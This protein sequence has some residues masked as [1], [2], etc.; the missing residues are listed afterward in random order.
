MSTTQYYNLTLFPESTDANVKQFRLALAGE[1]D[2][3]MTKIAAALRALETGKISLP[4]GA[5]DGKVLKA[6]VTGSVV[7]LVW[8]DASVTVDTS[9]VSTGTNAVSGKA[10]Y[11]YVAEVLGDFNAAAANMDALIGGS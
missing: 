3:N 11:D 9:V 8:G 10:V 5:A 7:T 4:A 6:S 2:S 1:T